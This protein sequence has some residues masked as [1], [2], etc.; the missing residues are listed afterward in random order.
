MDEPSFIISNG[1][2]SGKM[3]DFIRKIDAQPARRAKEPGKSSRL[4]SAKDCFVLTCSQFAIVFGSQ[5]TEVV[6]FNGLPVCSVVNKENV[7]VCGFSNGTV[8]NVKTQKKLLEGD[9]FGAVVGLHIEN[10]CDDETDVVWAA[11]GTGC[12]MKVQKDGGTVVVSGTAKTCTSMAISATHIALTFA[13]G[14][15]VLYDK[16]SGD[17]VC[18]FRGYFGPLLC[19]SFSPDGMFLAIG[20]EDDLVTIFSLESKQVL[21]RCRGCSSFVTRVSFCP[22]AEG[23]PYCL[24][25]VCEGR[26][27]FFEFSGKEEGNILHS[28]G[29][30]SRF[31]QRP[32]DA[33]WNVDGSLFV[34]ALIDGSAAIF[35]QM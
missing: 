17:L 29:D 14:E 34:V 7:V 24:A 19:A 25:A 22:T 6:H 32:S 2:G 10:D 3:F 12:V 21:F 4:S 30:C 18:S 11:F 13:T 31:T 35:K 28:V 16:C 5:L 15:C 20:G 33:L 8:L 26:V 27:S 23:K 1:G 9:N